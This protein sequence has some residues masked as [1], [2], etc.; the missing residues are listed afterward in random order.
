MAMVA[1]KY[2]GHWG[3]ISSFSAFTDT[4]L[5]S[6]CQIERRDGPPLSL[7]RLH[8][9]RGSNVILTSFFLLSWRAG[10]LTPWGPLVTYH[11]MTGWPLRISC[12]EFSF[13]RHRVLP[14]ID[15]KEATPVSAQSKESGN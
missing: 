1:A 13:G 5:E 6:R 2:H 15:E 14:E 12:T 11:M 3:Q 9:I 10:G 8:L 7:P 4:R